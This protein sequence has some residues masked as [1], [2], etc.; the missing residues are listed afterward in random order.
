MLG[1]GYGV[2][3]YTKFYNRD[4]DKYQALPY[5]YKGYFEVFPKEIHKIKMCVRLG[6]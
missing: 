3:Q 6:R 4:L 5:S 2:S 1:Y